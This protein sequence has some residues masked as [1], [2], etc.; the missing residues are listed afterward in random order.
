MK[1]ILLSHFYPRCRRDEYLGKSRVGLAAA[2]D[3][4]QYAIALG[5]NAVCDDFEIVNVPALFYYPFRYKEVSIPDEVIRENGLTIYNVG[6]NLLMEYTFFSQYRK[7]KI[8]LE[9]IVCKTHDIVYIVVYG[10]RSQ[11]MK[12]S[13]EIK[14]KYGNRIKIADIIPDLPQDVNTHGKSLSNVLAVLRAFYIKPINY[15][16]PKFDSYV[17]LTEYMRDVVPTKDVNYIVSEGIYE[18]TVTKRIQH[19]EDS[20]CF[21]LFYGGMLYEKFGIMNLVNAVHALGDQNIRLQL[22]GYGDCVDQVKELSQTDSRIQYLGVISR[23]E[24]LNYQSKASLLVNPRIPDGNPFTRY[25]FPSKTL[26]YF[27][28]GTP[29]LLYQLDGIPQEYYQYCYSLDKNH[30]SQNDLTGKILEIMAISTE[31][32][33]AMAHAARKFVLEEKNQIKSAKQIMDLLNRTV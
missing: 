9:D 31:K 8:A 3:A 22:C 14:E 1:V 23:D 29:T 24:V 28:S 17:L 4:H 16:F 2:A 7:T 6:Y 25:S 5:L 15:Y 32:R 11:A 19:Q 13:F 12:A 27:A 18:E 30:T 21:T 26:E 33:L 20:N 10:I